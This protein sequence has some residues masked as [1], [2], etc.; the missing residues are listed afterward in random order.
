MIES[1][2]G[3]PAVCERYRAGTG[4]WRSPP[5]HRAMAAAA[6]VSTAAPSPPLCLSTGNRGQRAPRRSPMP[7]WLCWPPVPTLAAQLA[8]PLPH[9]AKRRPDRFMGRAPPAACATLRAARAGPEKQ[10]E[11]RRSRTQIGAAARGRRARA[12]SCCVERVGREGGVGGKEGAHRK[13]TMTRQTQQRTNNE[14]ALLHPTAAAT[15][16]RPGRVSKMHE[17]RSRWT[18]LGVGLVST[19]P[20]D[21]ACRHPV[22]AASPRQHP[23]AHD[24]QEWE[25]GPRRRAPTY[26]LPVSPKRRSHAG[27]ANGRTPS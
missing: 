25:S 21:V 16:Q 12:C 14:P 13:R 10:T 18:N 11:R 4:L 9:Q 6:A 3:K 1:G 23:R 24:G 17:R 8:P 20:W 19:P 7:F 15:R 2:R 5:R 22:A 27:H 26:R